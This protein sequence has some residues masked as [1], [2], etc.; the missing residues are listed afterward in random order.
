R[1]RTARRA[2]SADVDAGNTTAGL[3]RVKRRHVIYVQGYDPRG[4]VEY[5]PLFRTEYRKFTAL[6]DLDGNIGRPVDQPG[7]FTTQ[8]QITT[9]GSGW[10]V[11][12]TYEFLRWEEII[13]RDFTR[14]V[15]WKIVNAWIAFFRSFIW[16]GGLILVARRNWRFAV[17][18]LFPYAFF[19]LH[20][21]FAILAGLLAIKLA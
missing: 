11:D 19:V 9:T 18:G 16:E 5:F 13:R 1:D 15:W 3:G 21:V 6:Y 20:I 4:L 7:R 17:F 14:P 10:Q 8:W 12:T 2:I